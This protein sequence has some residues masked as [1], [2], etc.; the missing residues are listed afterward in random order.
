[1][2]LTFI[3]SPPF[4]RS[5]A[6][7]AALNG[8]PPEQAARC[9]RRGGYVWYSSSLRRDAPGLIPDQF[10]AVRQSNPSQIQLYSF[11]KTKKNDSQP[12]RPVHEG[13]EFVSSACEH[14]EKSHRR[15][16]SMQ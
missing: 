13:V 5:V 7:H 1:M 12:R 9:T 15:R 3:A 2:Y 14:K 8:Q 11:N 4:K 10:T 16:K 6:S